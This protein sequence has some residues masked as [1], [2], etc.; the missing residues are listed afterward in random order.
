[1]KSLS[2]PALGFISFCSFAEDAR[3]VE[4]HKEFTVRFPFT[5]FFVPHTSCSQ[6]S[7]P[8][9]VHLGRLMKHFK[10]KMIPPESTLGTW[11]K[12]LSLQLCRQL[13]MNHPFT[14]TRQAQVPC[15]LDLRTC[16]PPRGARYHR[17]ACRLRDSISVNRLQALGALCISRRVMPPSRASS[18][19]SRRANDLI[20]PD[21]GDVSLFLY[22]PLSTCKCIVSS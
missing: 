11:S 17:H 6:V 15:R 14:L 16:L 1:M 12:A 2:G 18:L 7:F 19:G 4:Q 3:P 5:A 13:H 21:S 9:S 22:H 10:K 20:W 8:N